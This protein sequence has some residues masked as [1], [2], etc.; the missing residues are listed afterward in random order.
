MDRTLDKLKILVTRET[1]QRDALV[2]GLEARGAEVIWLPAI[3]TV[4]VEPSNGREV[5][6]DAGRFAWIVFTSPNGVRFFGRWAESAGFVPDP[7]VRVA[8]VGK[9]TAAT[10]RRAGWR[11]EATPPT[12]TGAE[13][14][15]TLGEEFP[16]AE[17]LLPRPVVARGEVAEALAA[18]GWTVT[19]FIVYETRPV[20][21]DPAG[22]A[23]LEHGV[24][25]AVF[26]SPS[27]LDGLWTRVSETARAALVAT[28]CVPIGPTTA[29][30]LRRV[31][32][33]PAIVPAEHSAGGILAALEDLFGSGGNR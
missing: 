18:A 30:A 26:A 31:G 25:A 13:L 21:L 9:S 2:D 12:F 22:L 20:V 29:K 8:C 6:A 3:E 7:D 10:A 23:A 32:L 27:A 4:P 1:R 17:A 28:R 14:G 19:P 11:V 16:P 15:K 24:D 5:L 33:E